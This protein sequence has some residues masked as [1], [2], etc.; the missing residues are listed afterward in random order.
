MSLSEDDSVDFEGILSSV[1]F[2][3]D[4]QN[5]IDQVKKLYT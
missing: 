4:V 3:K 2:P 1:T 5:A